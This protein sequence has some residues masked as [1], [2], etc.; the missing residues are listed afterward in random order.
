MRR[1]NYE[2]LKEEL[3]EDDADERKIEQLLMTARDLHEMKKPKASEATHRK[4][5]AMSG[6]TFAMPRFA[7]WSLA[8]G[9][10]VAMLIVAV[11]QFSTPGSALYAVKQV[12]DNI[13]AFVLPTKDDDLAE[14]QTKELKT[15]DMKDIPEVQVSETVDTYEKPDEKPKSATSNK[16]QDD[17]D[18]SNEGEKKSYKRWYDRSDDRD[19]RDRYRSYSSWSD[20]LFRSWFG[21]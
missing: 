21:R 20:D 7:G 4:I 1:M 13:Q 2:K 18:K 6:S 9:F 8:G 14:Q 5:R 10:A 19:D 12:T 15:M 11:A 17:N 16:K 3:T